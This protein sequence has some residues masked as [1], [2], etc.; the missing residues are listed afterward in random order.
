[1]ESSP[2][3]QKMESSEVIKERQ[4]AINEE[5]EVIK[6]ERN[7]E[8]DVTKEQITGE[9]EVVKEEVKEHIK[10]KIEE[11]QM[12]N[13]EINKEHETMKKEQ[14][15]EI[16]DEQE[17]LSF[18][19]IVKE[20]A[21]SYWE[22]N[23]Q[24]QAERSITDCLEFLAN[25]QQSMLP[26][27]SEK[28]W[29]TLNTLFQGMREHPIKIGILGEI[30]TLSMSVYKKR[31]TRNEQID[32]Q[33]ANVAD[34]QTKHPTISMS[35][36]A[37][38]EYQNVFAKQA[39]ESKESM[40][41]ANDQAITPPATAAIRKYL[42]YLPEKCCY[43]FSSAKWTDC[44]KKG[45][46]IGTSYKPDF[47]GY[48]C[49]TEG[50]PSRYLEVNEDETQITQFSMHPNFL[51]LEVQ[52]TPCATSRPLNQYVDFIR[53]PLPAIIDPRNLQNQINL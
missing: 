44:D 50:P 30:L 53:C 26:F 10:E 22:T 5:R 17:W 13:E 2:K 20:T 21:T 29:S 39:N 16:K 42:F 48:P 27:K 37:N 18:L 1:M 4:E 8:Q 7:E 23:W 51:V 24:Q 12:V 38:D 43:V 28:P 25:F 15:E 3:K 52:F 40:K 36:Q 49:A 31:A 32:A 46:Q 45:I 33:D 41:E 9:Q 34:N 6:D 47:R 19:E 14:E 11:E 35:R